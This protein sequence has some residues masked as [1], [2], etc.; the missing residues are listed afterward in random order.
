MTEID[1]QADVGVGRVEE[2]LPSPLRQVAGRAVGDHPRRPV[3]ETTPRRFVVAVPEPRVAEPPDEI[4]AVDQLGAVVD[5]PLP[6]DLVD[7]VVVALEPQTTLADAP[8]ELVQ[9]VVGM[10]AHEVRPP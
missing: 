10:V 2:E 8:R 7:V 3:A 4:A 1:E 9:L 5:G 6:V